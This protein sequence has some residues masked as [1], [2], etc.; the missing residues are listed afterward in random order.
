MA[1]SSARGWK[2][3]SRCSSARSRVTA[4]SMSSQSRFFPSAMNVSMSSGS[5]CVATAPSSEQSMARTPG[6]YSVVVGS[7]VAG[8]AVMASIVAPGRS[9]GP[10]LLSRRAGG[11]GAA[12]GR[13]ALDHAQLAVR[14]HEGGLH[15]G[16]VLDALLAQVAVELIQG[17]HLAAQVAPEDAAALHEL[18]RRRAQ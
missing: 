6:R 3:N 1:S 9:G 18:Q 15:L 7:L 14:L 13:V 11:A 5:T 8:S 4:V 16:D 17:D 12:P 10:L 2:P